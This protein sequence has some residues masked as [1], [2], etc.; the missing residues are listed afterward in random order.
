ML[1]AA[2]AAAAAATAAAAA[3]NCVPPAGG[4]VSD[5]VSVRLVSLKVVLP[6]PNIPLLL[7]A[8]LLPHVL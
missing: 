1:A 6:K 4:A 3:A 2:L 7:L 5:S 8:I